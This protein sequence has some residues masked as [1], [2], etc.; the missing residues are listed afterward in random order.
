MKSIRSKIMVILLSSIIT[1]A[2]LTGSLLTSFAYNAFHKETIDKMTN[3]VEK[4]AASFNFNLQKVMDI[5][6]NVEN[7]VTSLMDLEALNTNPN[8]LDELEVVLAP[9]IEGYAKQG[10]RT[11]SA[12]IF[13]NPELDGKSHDVWYADLDGNGVIRQNEFDL[14]FYDEFNETEDWYFIPKETLKPFWTDPYPGNADYDAHIIYISYTRPIVINNQFIGVTGSD[15]HFSVMR[16][17]I[18]EIAIYDTG[19]ALLLNEDYDVMVHKYLPTNTN[20]KDYK[21][22][23]YEFINDELKKADSGYFEYVWEDGSKKI[24]VYQRLNNGWTFGMAVEEKEVYQWLYQTIGL[25]VILSF[26]I[27]SIIGI[28]G[29]R[30]TSYL[31]DNLTILAKHV[32]VIGDGDYDQP[33]PKKLKLKKD[34][35]GELAVNI[36]LMRERQKESFETLKS[37]NEGL[38][39]EIENRTK[40]LKESHHQLEITLHENEE[41]NLALN[42]MNKQLSQVIQDMET[43]KRQLI[44]SE[45][46]ASLSMLV[47]KLAHEFNTPVGNMTTLISFMQNITKSIEE[48][49]YN[50]NL[51]K[52]DLSDYIQKINESSKL[53][54]ENLTTVK[55]LVS[56]F[57]ELDP[58]SHITIKSKIN[59]YDYINM[60]V[61]SIPYNMKRI[62]VEILCDKNLEVVIDSGKLSSILFH[63]ID[64]AVQHGLADV[65][66]GL[67]VIDV[68][69]RSPQLTIVV[70]DNGVGMSKEMLEHIFVPFYSGS[71]S[72]DSS[73]LGLNIVYNI[74]TTIF[75]GQINCESIENDYTQFLITLN[76]E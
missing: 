55:M 56:R 23:Q 59:L 22:G 31:T 27:I 39:T 70:K 8:Y 32:K 44:E 9:V 21:S 41:K 74:V 17:D 28:G 64:N 47:T 38:E 58:A 10:I 29:Y 18:N 25:M 24:M 68:F 67:I 73:G 20:L 75:K 12:Y 52:H 40:S 65:D 48:L 51:K 69:Y 30:I 63:L 1:T 33:I 76:L 4:Y 61:N 19:Y 16:D 46:L 43:T 37:Y 26:V 45:K 36:E 62:S 60:V 34:E 11:K 13:F 7:M 49:F 14:S 50:Q 53:S 6:I 35:T 57:K 15:Y 54:N 71:L 42:E 3:M 5:A 2:L 66:S 72:K